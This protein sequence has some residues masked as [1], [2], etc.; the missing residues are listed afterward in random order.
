M[1]IK[2]LL[3]GSAAA[4]VA[5]SGARAADAI[6][7]AEPEPVEYVRVCDAFGTGYFYIPGTETCLRIHGYVRYDIGAGDLFAVQSATGEDTYFK[8]AR[9]SFRV[10][11]ASETELGTL[12]TYVETRWQYDTN[13]ASN[14]AQNLPNTLRGYTNDNEFTV[15][16]AW[17]QL[18]GLRVGKDESLFTTFTGYAGAVINDG[19][20]GPFDTNLISYTYNGGAFRAAI[21][22]EQGVSSVYNFAT[23]TYTGWGIDD[24]MPH[25]VA[26][27][28]YNAGMFDVSAVLG[29]DTRED[30]VS[31]ALTLFQRG[32]WAGK[33]RADVTINDQASLFA[34]VMYGENTSAYTTWANG[35]ATDETL[36]VIAGGT[37]KA[38]DK[39]AF[40]TQIQWVDSNTLADDAW[41][42]VGNLNY[43]V[44]PGLV[45]TPEVVWAD[46]GVTD[47]FGFYGRVQRSF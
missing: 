46:N 27:V 29:Y 21:G 15:N 42:V 19:S 7:A 9:F 4:L 43:T 6:V 10:S 1:N 12:R 30:W 8:R 36:S 41:T 24:Y 39:L 25:V 45:V 23:D 13:N 35:A 18:G 28:G 33:I 11:T 37:Y 40:N 17:I 31:P 38:S 26:G 2:S 44:V 47:A 22:V 34:M 5:V 32:G 3:L 20:Y 14:A 16:F